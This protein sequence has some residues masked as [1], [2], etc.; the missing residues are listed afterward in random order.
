[1]IGVLT[2]LKLSKKFPKMKI[3]F[4]CPKIKG[5]ASVAS[6]AMLNTIG[7]VDNGYQFDNYQ[8]TKIRLGLQSQ[9]LWDKLLKEYS[10]FENVKTADKTV[11]FC[12]KDSTSLERECFQEINR[13]NLISK[14]EGKNLSLIKKIKKKILV[15]ADFLQ[16]KREGAINTKDFFAAAERIIKKRKNIKTF[17]YKVENVIFKNNF[18]ELNVKNKKIRSKKAV[19]T[20]GA[21]SKSLIRKYAKNI[22]KNY[23]G[24]G[25]AL[26]IKSKG[27]SN[28]IGKRTVLRTPNRGSTCGIHL[29]PR[30]ET[31]FYLGAGSNISLTP[32]YEPRFGTV[33]YLINSL[34]NE[35]SDEF[36]KSNIR[37]LV[38]F[39]PMSFDGRPLIGALKKNE[40][41]F[42]IGGLKRDG[43]TLAPK[44]VEEISNWYCKKNYNQDI[45]GEWFPERKPISYG[46]KEFAIETYVKNKICGLIEHDLIKKSIHKV[47]KELEN[48]AYKFH[49]EKIK[50]FN[51]NEKFGVH[52]EILNV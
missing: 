26:E 8:N 36:D 45:F 11:V 51:L 7:E 23:Y 4:F 30:N 27:L 49:K 31:E 33:E 17:N 38:G 20:S 14:R 35:I 24:I 5:G 50:L 21:F 29:V 15:K 42:F 40:N 25:T 2:A 12:K 16:I 22:Q 1:M 47:K 6:G 48:E 43:L 39:R 18:V 37:I 41:V 46:N 44:I 13:F 19:I 28:I 9:K 3:A 10:E 32:N 34:K 52:P